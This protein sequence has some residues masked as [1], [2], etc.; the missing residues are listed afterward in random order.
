MSGPL[1]IGAL[2]EAAGVSTRTV[3]YYEQRGLLTPAGHSVGGERRYD[4]VSLARLRRIRELADI[5]GSD[6]DEIGAV[7]AAE[8]RLATLRA[9]RQAGDP[10]PARV[11]RLAE[12]EAINAGLQARVRDRIARL[13]S[14]LDE[15]EAR[16]LYY[17]QMRAELSASSLAAPSPRQV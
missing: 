9:R 17:A 10:A 1:R 6:L 15:L 11:A 16:S 5:L 13:Q 12:A 8:D 4:E 14:M 7:L 3:R 2:A